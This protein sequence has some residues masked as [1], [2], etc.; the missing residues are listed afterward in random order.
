MNESL[1]RERD[2]YPC[3][4]RT[5]Y[6]DTITAI[7]R[8]WIIVGVCRAVVYVVSQLTCG[9]HADEVAPDRVVGFD[10]D[11]MANCAD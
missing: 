5:D 7:Q 9:V 10:G 1:Y 11:R 4:L 2:C 8:V 6:P 3:I